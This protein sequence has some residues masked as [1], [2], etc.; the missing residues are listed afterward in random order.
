[1]PTLNVDNAIPQIRG[2]LD[3]KRRRESLEM[4]A[5]FSPVFFLLVYVTQMLTD[6]PSAYHR[7]STL[8]HMNHKTK[9][10]C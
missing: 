6:A 8:D 3:G 7:G 4:V 10:K 2:T 9:C 1:M 5:F